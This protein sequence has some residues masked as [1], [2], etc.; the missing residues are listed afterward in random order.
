[1]IFRSFSAPSFASHASTVSVD[2]EPI[3]PK[4]TKISGKTNVA[5]RHARMNFDFKSV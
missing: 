5:M 2:S 3:S 1:M 4:F